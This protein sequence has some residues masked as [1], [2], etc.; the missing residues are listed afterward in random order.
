M[1]HLPWLSQY[2][3]GIAA[4]IDLQGYPS[5]AALL[6]QAVACFGN[7]IAFHQFGVDLTF[8]QL[9]ET[10]AR[11][12]AYF[13][14]DLGLTRGDRIALML[15]NSLQHP[16][17]M[18]AALRAGLTVVNVNPLYT[19]AELTQLKGFRCACDRRDGNVRRHRRACADPCRH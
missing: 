7:K 17:A 4:D 11:L 10:S 8:R 18:F 15:P 13:Q 19:A 14:D 16:I 9:D 1:S 2:P 5:M 6:E 3:E 12:A